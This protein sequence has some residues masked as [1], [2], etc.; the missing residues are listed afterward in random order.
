M[1]STV[2][3]NIFLAYIWLSTAEAL[4]GL[5]KIVRTRYLLP[6]EYKRNFLLTLTNFTSCSLLGVNSC[7]THFI[8]K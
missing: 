7:A 5:F 3:Q 2:F 6:K 8:L 4:A 1:N